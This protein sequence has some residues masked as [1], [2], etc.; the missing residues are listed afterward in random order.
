M[1]WQFNDACEKAVIVAAFNSGNARTSIIAQNFLSL[2]AK[3]VNATLR[4]PSTIGGC[5]LED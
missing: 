2:N 1:H 3:V 4:F 5:K